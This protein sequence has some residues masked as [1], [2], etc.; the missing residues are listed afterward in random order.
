MITMCKVLLSLS[1]FLLFVIQDPEHGN[2]VFSGACAL[3]AVAHEQYIP[4]SFT[5]GK[6]VKIPFQTPNE[7]NHSLR[8]VSSRGKSF[9]YS[10]LQPKFSQ[11]DFPMTRLS[12]HFFMTWLSRHPDRKGETF[13]K[14][15]SR[16]RPKLTFSSLLSCPT[17]SKYVTFKVKWSMTCP[18][19]LLSFCQFVHSHYF[20]TVLSRHRLQI[21]RWR[22]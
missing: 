13:P 9:R 8:I 14:Y 22:L 11:A 19:P 6:K 7:S 17:W 3:S 15:V 12:S 1:F 4:H 18:I 10:D 2:S 21:M 5:D 20:S 16:Y